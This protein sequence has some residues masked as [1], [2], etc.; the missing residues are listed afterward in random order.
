M[1]YAFH[2]LPDALALTGGEY[3]GIT[4]NGAPKRL[5]LT[6]LPGGGG[7]G[8]AVWGTITGTLT[9]QLDLV[10]YVASQTANGNTAYGW[11]NHASAGYLT[12]L[13]AH[14]HL[15]SDITATPTTLAG[16]GITDA[17]PLS[18]NP[19]GYLTTI[20]AHTHDA[21]D[22]TTG[23]LAQARGGTGFS[24]YAAG[25]LLYASAVNTLSKRSIGTAGQVLTVVSGMPT[26]ATASGGGSGVTTMAAI[27]STPNANAA[28]ISGT[29]LNLQP[30]SASFGGVVTTAAQSFAGI[31]TFSSQI[32]IDFG[33]G[34]A[35]SYTGYEGLIVKRNIAG[36][37]GV[38]ITLIAGASGPA[39]IFFGTSATQNLGKIGYS[40]SSSSFVFGTA[41]TSRMTL[42]STSLA[43]S[44]PISVTINSSGLSGAS[45]VNSNA[46]GAASF[47]IN[48]DG[49]IG[50]FRTY[51][52][53]FAVTSIRNCS[54][55]GSNL[56][57]YAVANASGTGTSGNVYLASGTSAA[58]ILVAVGATS[59]ILI[60][61]ITDVASSILTVESGNK[62]FLPPRMTTTQKNAIASPAAGLIVYDTTLAKLCVY[63]TAWETITSV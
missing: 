1:S 58:A 14:G 15:W 41:G 47:N 4:Q 37:Y 6:A 28:T 57:V 39:D 32:I 59:N 27:G 24:T 16:Y 54:S 31:K 46:S 51:G 5:L 20:G 33:T 52:S 44:V 40:M 9:D 8:A 12:A 18:S 3:L 29:T 60:G 50:Y 17:Y 10:A 42:D 48:S 19:A 53:A 49:G 21:A 22:I 26:W 63:T 61:T 13:P 38:N 62:G 35:P 45:I 7:G 11:G 56:S 2:K 30:A 36:A 55:F 34:T 23:T 43:L 25:D